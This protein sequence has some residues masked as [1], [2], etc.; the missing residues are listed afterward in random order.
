MEITPERFI[1]EIETILRG[2]ML[3]QVRRHI[4]L[5]STGSKDALIE[6]AKVQEEERI[7]SLSDEFGDELVHTLKHDLL[8][9]IAAGLRRNL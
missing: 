7:E 3:A 8:P 6:I 2:R 5:G 9:Q 4:R 1:Q